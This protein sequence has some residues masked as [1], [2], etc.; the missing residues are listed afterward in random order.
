MTAI[1]IGTGDG[2][3]SEVKM[4]QH[5]PHHKF[6]INKAVRYI[7]CHHWV[8]LHPDQMISD[9]LG[10]KHSNLPDGTR[11]NVVWDFKNNGG[12][13]ALLAI[14]ITR[15]LLYDKVILCGVPLSNK[16]SGALNEFKKYKEKHFEWCKRV[17]SFSG[18]TKELFGD[19]KEMIYG[20]CS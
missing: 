3:L 20:K 17:R 4:V 14:D 9:H 15:R 1:I 5:I 2:F 7:S 6:G 10:L 8:S 16:Y 19:A 11:I 13:S 18:L 12:T